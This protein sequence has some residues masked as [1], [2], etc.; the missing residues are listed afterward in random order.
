ITGTN[1][2]TTTAHLIA[3]AL[4]AAGREVGVI[5]T[6]TGPRTTPEATELQAR[7]AGLR[8]EGVDSVVME[9]SSHAL[10]LRRVDGTTFD[11]AVFTNLGRDHLDLHGSVEDY[12]RAK[13][14]LFTP[15]LTAVGVINADDPYGRLLLD[16]AAIPL[17]AYSR[18]DAVDVEV[19]AAR[20]RFVWRGRRVDVPLGGAF[21]VMNT[22]AALTAVDVLGVDADDA[23]AGMSSMA[24]VPGRFEVISAASPGPTVIVDYAHTPDGITELLAAAREVTG[25]G[26][27]TI[28]FGCGGDRDREKR[29]QM[30]MAAAAGADRVIVTSDN[31]RGEDPLTIIEAIVAG[32]REHDRERL[33]VE[34]DRRA[35][36]ERAVAGAGAEDVVVVAGKGHESTQTIGTTVVE[37]DDRVVA[38]EM[39]E[40]RS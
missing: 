40:A 18:S 11:T 36:I 19:T 4:R 21:N 22:L 38:R 37:F 20:H 16:V 24:P 30:G 1:G 7:L 39:L 31:P 35:A 6:L 10:A 13:A 29:P 33:V 23:A 15:E 12:F 9:V 32:V 17:R 2:K 27:V 26:V 14:R 34:P 5:G 3:A 28:V 25:S 8:D